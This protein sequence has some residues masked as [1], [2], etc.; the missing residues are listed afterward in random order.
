MK[1]SLLLLLALSLVGLGCSADFEQAALGGPIDRDLDPGDAVTDT[2]W[3]QTAEFCFRH[4]GVAVDSR[5]GTA[6]VVQAVRD[7]WC[8]EVPTKTLWAIPMGEAQPRSLLDL[9]DYEDIRI[10]F[11]EDRV[12]VMAESN[13]AEVMFLLD[14]FDLRIVAK[15]Q[16]R[17]RYFASRTSPS[18]RFVT[19]ADHP[20]QTGALHIIDTRELVTAVIPHGGDTIEARWMTGRDRLVAV[21]FYNEPAGRYAR[22]L[23]WDFDT[24]AKRPVFRNSRGGLWADPALDVRVDGLIPSDVFPWIEVRADDAY[25]SLMARDLAGEVVLVVLDMGGK[26]ATMYPGLHGPVAWTAGGQLAGWRFGQD[27]V[28]VIA[29]V[30]ETGAVTEVGFLNRPQ[31]PRLYAHP[32]T[33][34]VVGHQTGAQDSFTVFDIDGGP[35]AR[36]L[37]VDFGLAEAVALGEDDV[38]F[39]ASGKLNRLNLGTAESEVPDIGASVRR[40]ALLGEGTLVLTSGESPAVLRL[41]VATME[42]EQIELPPF[43]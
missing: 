30:P 7:Y 13:G 29:L 32:R 5:T 40:L 41:D 12:L 23:A 28:E 27:E 16:S 4:G 9:S 26:T 2:D 25:V 19:V 8:R 3:I 38:W 11:P 20:E 35:A 39:V 36:G 42:T 17:S 10:T 24:D 18:R 43:P 1:S 33:N 34:R 37:V 21:V 15:L 14:P 22:L 31:G 6:F